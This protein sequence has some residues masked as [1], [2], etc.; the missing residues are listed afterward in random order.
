MKVSA[1][2]EEFKAALAEAADDMRTNV[3]AAADTAAGAITERGRADIAAGGRFG[4]AWTSAFK[5]TVEDEGSRVVIEA[6]MGGEPPVSYWKIFEYGAVIKATNPSG[7]L[8]IPFD[9]KNKVWPRDY[10]GY[11]KSL[12][13]IDNVLFD[14]K[15]D[16]PMYLGTPQVTIPQ[17]FH[18]RDIVAQVAN[19]LAEY[20]K[21]LRR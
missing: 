21:S 20:Y 4:T 2:T 17:K 6:K 1:N 16:E 13:R 10:P 14:K 8:W 9:E 15:T 5:A 7:L 19:E 11:P 3:R 18:L 12:F